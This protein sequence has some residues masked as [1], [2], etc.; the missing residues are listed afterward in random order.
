MSSLLTSS[1][2]KLS[3]SKTFVAVPTAIGVAILEYDFSGEI[4]SN[5]I[6][7]IEHRPPFNVLWSH[8]SYHLVV[9]ACDFIYLYTCDSV[10]NGCHKWVRARTVEAPRNLL[11][12]QACYCHPLLSIELVHRQPNHAH[13][14]N[15]EVV[16]I[17]LLCS[18]FQTFSIATP[19]IYRGPKTSTSQLT[20]HSANRLSYS[21]RYLSTAQ[22]VSSTYNS[23][24]SNGAQT[25]GVRVYDLLDLWVLQSPTVASY[26]D[27]KY[28]DLAVYSTPAIETASAD[29]ASLCEVQ[30][31]SG[32]DYSVEAPAEHQHQHQQWGVTQVEWRQIDKHAMSGD[33]FELFFLAQHHHLPGSGGFSKVRPSNTHKRNESVGIADTQHVH[34]DDAES[35]APPVRGAHSDVTVSIYSVSQQPDYENINILTMAYNAAIVAGQLS[36]QDDYIMNISQGNYSGIHSGYASSSNNDIGA[37]LSGLSTPMTHNGTNSKVA[38]TQSAT[39]TTTINLLTV[40][41]LGSLYRSVGAAAPDGAA[42]VTGHVLFAWVES[43]AE[44]RTHPAAG[45]ARRS[46]VASSGGAKKSSSKVEDVDAPLWLAVAHD[47]HPSG[48]GVPRKGYSYRVFG[49]KYQP[50]ADAAQQSPSAYVP[51]FFSDDSIRTTSSTSATT[52]STAVTTASTTDSP[53]VAVAAVAPLSDFRVLQGFRCVSDISFSSLSARPTGALQQDKRSSTSQSQTQPQVRASCDVTFQLAFASDTSSSSGGGDRA[54]SSSFSSVLLYTITAQLGVPPQPPSVAAVAS[55]PTASSNI[56][57]G[58]GASS[59]TILSARLLDW[60]SSVV[61]IPDM[62]NISSP[63]PSLPLRMLVKSLLPSANV[64]LTPLNATSALFQELPRHLPTPASPCLH[65]RA[66]S[67]VCCLVSLADIGVGVRVDGGEGGEG[68]GHDRDVRVVTAVAVPASSTTAAVRYL[69]ILYSAAGSLYIG[70]WSLDTSAEERLLAETREAQRDRTRSTQVAYDSATISTTGGGTALGAASWRDGFGS[71]QANKTTAGPFSST[72]SSGTTA[73]SNL[74]M[75]E[76]TVQVLPDPHFGLGIR[77]DVL[78]G[79]T[80]VSSFKKHPLSNQPMS[81]QLTG[82]IQVGDEF[83]AINGKHLIGVRVFVFFSKN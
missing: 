28:A 15:G 45:I 56:G 1:G 11:D 78:D 76:Y 81:A 75:E 39:L 65:R 51:V 6:Q 58:G 48:T 44:A 5:P 60:R 19:T 77:I 62:A 7:T 23:G 9:I 32:G 53:P 26:L 27:F 49:V 24:S 54:T 4:D 30:H 34:I 41:S 21:G 59:P 57:G 61:N 82:C 36:Q 74:P 66:P 67:P 79:R 38:F 69:Y 63:P 29:T 50:L 47:A 83:V 14:T 37:N 71:K 68:D 70:V 13:A 33:A 55:G 35:T 12:F 64:G 31:Q 20:E 18:L 40:V 17:N 52:T 3:L 72:S 80:V 8:N 10:G 2:C 16:V 42:E 25:L 46:P 22:V 73:Q 43:A